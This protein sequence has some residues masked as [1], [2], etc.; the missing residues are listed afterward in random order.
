VAAPQGLDV[1]AFA[2]TG[3]LVVRRFVPADAAA[4]AA[5][6]SDPSV[7]RYQSWTAPFAL[8][9]ARHLVSSFA[10]AAEEAEGW[11]QYAV[12]LR[13]EETLIGD[14]GVNRLGRVAEL[15]FTMAPAYQGKGYATEAVRAV[16][17]RLFAAG[18]HKVSAECD[19][20]NESSAR[21]LTRVGFTRE[22]LRREHTWLKGEWTDDLLFGLLARDW[23]P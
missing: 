12:A 13:G 6:R 17:A 16:L 19:A 9:E 18:V 23:H 2:A 21:L 1:T 4:F 7:A 3:R 11:F 20:R 15:G 5:Y 22:G 10:T 8:A 14:V